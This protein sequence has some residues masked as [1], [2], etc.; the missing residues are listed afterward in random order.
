MNNE[1]S[2]QSINLWQERYGSPEYAYGKEPNLFFKEWLTQLTPK[3]I[4]MPAD[5][6]GR[7]GVYAATLGWKV[8]SFD[9]SEEG[10]LKAM[11]LASQHNVRLDYFVG[12]LEDM[13]FEKESFDVI[14]LIYAHFQA[15]MISAYHHALSSY[16]K[17][18]GM[19]ILEAFSKNHLQFNSVDPKVG[20]PKDIGLLF[21]I[22]QIKTDFELYGIELLE[23]KQIQLNEG[24]YHIGE[25]SVIRFVGRKPVSKN[26]QNI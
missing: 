7:N 1:Q 8:T 14:G 20:G 11:N 2:K 5:G 22:E 23:E 6:E 19:V 17:P 9:M 15:D 13:E 12:S 10:S 16:L 3:T 4:L 18:G 26:Y 25:G 21:S 24:I